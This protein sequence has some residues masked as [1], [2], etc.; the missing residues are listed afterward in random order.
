[1]NP[2]FA[3]FQKIKKGQK[4]AKSGNI[5]VKAIESGKILMP[6]YQAQGEDGFLII[7][8]VKKIWIFIS[9]ILRLSGMEILLSALPGVKRGDVSNTMVINRKIA[10]IYPMQIFHLFGF[11]RVDKYDNVLVVSKRDFDIHPPTAQQIR[12]RFLAKR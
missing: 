5:D 4:L 6:L 7:R 2:G 11:R 8:R 12:Q 3:N 1:M 9:R 10:K